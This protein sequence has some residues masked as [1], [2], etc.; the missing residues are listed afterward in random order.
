MTRSRRTVHGG[1]ARRAFW[2]VRAICIG[3]GLLIVGSFW[4]MVQELLLNAGS[5]SSNAPPVGAVGLFAAVVTVVLLLG[6]IRARWELGRKELLV[7]Y[8]MLVTFFPLASEG[9]WHRFVGMLISV[10]LFYQAQ[11]PAHMIPRGPELLGNRQFEDGL[12]HWSGQAAAYTYEHNN[13]AR[14]AALLSNDESEALCDLVQR[15]ERRG[16]DGRDRF[17]PGQKF[18]LFSYVRRW[19]F[20]PGS[21]MSIAMSVDGQRWRNLS[22]YAN[23]DSHDLTVDGSGLELMRHYSIEIPYGVDEQLYLRWRLTGVGRIVIAST[24]FH[25]NEPIHRLFDGSGEVAAR[26]DAQIRR[27]DRARLLLR[28]ESG[29]QRLLYD[30][31]GP[32]PWGSWA[33]PLLS[34]GLL[35]VAMF[36]AMYALGAVLF[37]QWSDREKL[38]FPLTAVPLLLTEPADGRGRYI[39]KIIRSRALWAGVL[40]AVLIYLLNGLNFYN[41]DFPR[42]S[43]FV[44]LRQYLT[45]PPWSALTEDGRL[46]ALRVV[47]LGVGVAFFMDLQMSFSLWFFFLLCKLYM[48]V[49]FFQGKLETRFWSRGPFYG[50]GLNQFQGVGAAVGV[51]LIALWLG[52]RHLVDVVRKTF[53]PARSDIDDSREP[54]PYRLAMLMLL[55]SLVLLGIWGQIAGAGWLFGV[56]GMGVMLMFAIMASRIRAECAAP[57]MWLVPATP[58]VMLMAMGGMV[59]FG[60][61]PMTYFLMAGNFMCAGLFL[62]IMPALMETFQIAKIARIRR[63]VIGWAMVVGF[64]VSVLS[65]GYLML[66]WGYARGVST[67]RGAITIKD[68]YNSVLW[69]WRVE[70]EEADHSLNR[71]S[72]VNEMTSLDRPLTEQEQIE[73]SKLRE[74]PHVRSE[75]CWIAAVGTG[76]TCLLAWIRLTFLQFPFHPLGYALASTQLMS[77]FWF[78]IFIAWLVRL[79]GLRLGGVRMV[80]NH[81]QPYMIGLILGSVAAVLIWDAVAVYKVAGGYSGDVYVTW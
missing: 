16:P 19:D 48:L 70:T 53:N 80:R 1:P 5:L 6:W 49:P 66:M 30:L 64:A 36:M 10:R 71:Q 14:P 32:V 50:V 46:F 13:T 61:L 45:K 65:G 9:L 33:K 21:W 4:I 24:S 81:L 52:R 73:L 39:P 69:Q 76:I 7:I 43:L 34:W 67:L 28:P 60:V 8:C 29:W 56:L 3:A 2:P 12:D 42:L 74:R 31:R 77:Y 22:F 78:S 15:I 63:K 55:G 41:A 75:A 23:R 26:H 37:R 25:S 18:N 62:M 27:N 20:V 17:T 11:V 44:D 47:L 58:V 35:W 40:T 57:G 51:V 68:D 79:L 59:T 54:M 72:Q 38:T